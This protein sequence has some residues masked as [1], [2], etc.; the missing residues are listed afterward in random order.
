MKCFITWQD[1][2]K[3]RLVDSQFNFQIETAIPSTRQLAKR[4]KKGFEAF[5]QKVRFIQT[6]DT[7]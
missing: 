7:I 5:N 2:I 1:W 4:E 6:D 3:P